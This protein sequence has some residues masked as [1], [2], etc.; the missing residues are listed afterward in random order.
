MGQ[1]SFEPLLA[2]DDALTGTLLGAWA[3]PCSDPT[4]YRQIV[5][6]HCP[7]PS[8]PAFLSPLPLRVCWCKYLQVRSIPTTPLNSL[9][10]LKPLASKYFL[11]P[12]WRSGPWTTVACWRVIPTPFG[13]LWLKSSQVFSNI[14]NL[15]LPKPCRMVRMLLSSWFI[16]AWTPSILLGRP[17]APVLPFAATPECGP[18]CFSGDVPLSLLDIPLN[19]PL[20]FGDKTDSAFEPFKESSAT[21]RS[22]YSSALPCQPH[23]PY[24]SYH[25]FGRGTP[26]HQPI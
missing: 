12:T 19:D 14:S 21:A 8:N 16:V 5:R 2:F 1:T 9:N 25:G 20:L 13:I 15:P 6:H 4:E 26:Y 3:K 23:Q 7:A 18:L 11:L 10:A 22:L 24:R 17:S